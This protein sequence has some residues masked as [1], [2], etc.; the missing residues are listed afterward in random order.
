MSDPGLDASADGMVPPGPWPVSGCADL[1]IPDQ[2]DLRFVAVADDR[3][4]SVHAMDDLVACGSLRW[5]I[6]EN[7]DDAGVIG[8]VF[9]EPERRRT[10]VATALLEVARAYA[11]HYGLPAPRHSET[12]SRG[13]EEWGRS[14]GAP[15]AKEIWDEETVEDVVGRYVSSDGWS[16]AS[17]L[18]PE[19]REFLIASEGL[20]PDFADAVLEKMREIGEPAWDDRPSGAELLRV[21]LSEGEQA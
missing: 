14:L 12:R 10:G 1:R 16:I 3:R 9:V 11:Q 18:D 2:P 4:C 15:E 7:D 8:Y 6:A 20:A 13:G 19:M 17:P 5:L 21:R